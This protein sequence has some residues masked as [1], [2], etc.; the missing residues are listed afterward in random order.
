M[1]L[2]ICCGEVDFPIESTNALMHEGKTTAMKLHRVNR[3]RSD[4]A[5]SASCCHHAAV[6]MQKLVIF[7]QAAVT[8]QKFVIFKHAAVT[9]QNS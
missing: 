3:F 9:M 8:T 7:K 1:Y 5:H 4:Y 6:T 2:A